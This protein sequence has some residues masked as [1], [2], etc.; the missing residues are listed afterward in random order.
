M[1]ETSDQ[2]PADEVRNAEQALTPQPAT[3]LTAQESAAEAP[4]APHA[5][6]APAE[7]ESQPTPEAAE[8]TD[9]L[10]PVCRAYVRKLGGDE[11]SLA[12]PFVRRIVEAKV[13]DDLYLA[14]SRREAELR[15]AQKPE[16]KKPAVSPPAPPAPRLPF[17]TLKNIAQDAARRMVSD[18]AAALLSPQ[19]YNAFSQRTAALALSG[20]EKE[21]ALR[22]PNRAITEA[23]TATGTLI[24]GDLF[25]R[26]IPGM[27]QEH[28]RA[29]VQERDDSRRQA[30][31][32]YR[33]A[34][35]RVAEEPACRALAWMSQED[36]QRVLNHYRRT[37]GVDLLRQQF[38][39]ADGRAL[40]PQGNAQVQYRTLVR[41]AKQHNLVPA[42][43]LDPRELRR[44]QELLKAQQ[45][46]Q[47]FRDILADEMQEMVDSFPLPMPK[48]PS[49][50]GPVH[51]RRSRRELCAAADATAAAS[52]LQGCE[53][54][55]GSRCQLDRD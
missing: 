44:R 20:K 16:P 25:A 50:N 14:Q 26:L 15:E 39:F 51:R 11:T 52:W 22:Q 48:H 54:H 47:S 55:G 6:E 29:K 5:A 2:T 8:P 28:V 37:T 32:M 40:S 7:G 34:F 36:L 53:Q 3:D 21:E 12:N 4:E 33:W 10:D 1:E 9:P 45:R 38:Q 17:S 41:W 30:S 19:L 49:D 27:V 13:R 24:M 18:E 43:P 42:Q 31:A 46:K 23:A 35:R